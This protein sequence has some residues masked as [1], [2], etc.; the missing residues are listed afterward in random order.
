[1]KN[2]GERSENRRAL[3]RFLLIMLAAG[4]V[5]GVLGFC[6]GVIGGSG[7]NVKIAAWLDGSMAAAAPWGIP[8]T[9]VVTLGICLGLYRS[10]RRRY[11]E[12]DGE[13]EDVPERADE[14]LNWVLLLNGLQLMCNLFFFAATSHY[15]RGDSTL[16]SV[17][18]FLLSCG[19]VIFTQ[20]KVVDLTKRFNPEKRGSVY[21]TK[22]HK[23]WMDSCDEAERQQVGQAAFKAFRTACNACMGLWL[24]LVIADMEFQVGV[25]PSFVV[26]LLWGVLQASYVL[27][28]I[29]ISR[30][31]RGS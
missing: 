23:K 13:D 24:V 10:A 30:G 3:P 1:M 11:G 6:T 9:S 26:L 20:Q 8:V 4:L 27:E 12:W 5:G 17:G 28:C 29:R 15:R 21:D 22:F 19:A 18:V 7:L 2:R 16:V 31:R 14:T 25:L